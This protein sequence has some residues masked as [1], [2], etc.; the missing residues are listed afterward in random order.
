M[1]IEVIIH[2]QSADPVLGEIDVLPDPT[3]T[4]IKIT[5]PRHRDGKDLH[6]LNNNVVDVYWP[7][8]QI[9]FIEI[10]PSEAE[11]QIVGFVRE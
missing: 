8:Q 3:D 9:T 6:Y 2:F 1:A 5:N 7:I 11:E 4:L 10:L